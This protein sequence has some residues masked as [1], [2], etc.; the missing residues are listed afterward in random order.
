M[1]TSGPWLAF[2]LVGSGARDVNVAQSLRASPTPQLRSRLWMKF[3]FAFRLVVGQ[4]PGLP[5]GGKRQ[6][7]RLPY[8]QYAT[9][10]CS[11]RRKAE[12]ER[13]G[14]A[15][16]SIQRTKT[17]RAVRYRVRVAQQSVTDRQRRRPL[18]WENSHR[19]IVRHR[20]P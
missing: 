10:D 1:Y 7:Q 8:K 12:R 13:E 19:I 16:K 17:R 20:A 4:A 2:A 15:A 11:K 9:A 14:S 5:V 18:E 3:V 6:P